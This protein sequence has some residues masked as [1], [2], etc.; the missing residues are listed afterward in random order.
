M[1][2]LFR[3]NNIYTNFKNYLDSFRN[4]SNKIYNI[5]EQNKV[6]NLSNDEN[7]I[8][9]ETNFN[10]PISNIYKNLDSFI[11]DLENIINLNFT[12]EECENLIT[13]NICNIIKYKTNLS[14]YEY[15]YNIVKLRNGSFYTKLSLEN[16]MNIFDDLNYDEILNI[17]KYNKFE[18]SLNN[19]NIFNIYNSTNIKLSQINTFSFS[20][21]EEQNE[22]FFE[23]I[24]KIYSLNNDYYPFL[25]KLEQILK[26]KS[27]SYNDYYINFIDSKLKYIDNLINEFNITLYKQKE[28]YSLYNIDKNNMFNNI[29]G[30]YH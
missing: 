17:E 9:T 3:K 1:N 20:F 12:Y 25:K 26:L 30:N 6:L 21:F 29:Y 4:I 18:N 24:I 27:T 14:N 19:K 8:L 23:D 7:F 11:F 10:Q 15:N 5:Q 28:K 16:T 2:F 22:Y 13:N